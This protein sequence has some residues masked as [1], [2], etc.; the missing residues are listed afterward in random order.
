MAHTPWRDVNPR[1]C[2]RRQTVNIL[3]TPAD[4]YWL[5]EEDTLAKEEVLA[6]WE[7]K[8]RDLSLRARQTQ[9]QRQQL[10]HELGDVQQEYADASQEYNRLRA[11]Y[12]RARTIYSDAPEEFS[13]M[14]PR[15][16]EVMRDVRVDMQRDIEAIGRRLARSEA[17]LA[18]V[19]EERDAMTAAFEEV[20]ER[21]RALH[22]QHCNLYNETVDALDAIYSRGRPVV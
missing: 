12:N 7:T 2:P 19:Q 14:Y 21:L 17:E 3:S 8:S 6:R 9:L 15:Q 13:V 18:A 1:A 20:S 4:R 10:W 16:L 11:A 22:T 5:S